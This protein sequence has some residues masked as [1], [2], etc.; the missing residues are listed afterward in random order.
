MAAPPAPGSIPSP[1]PP[2]RQSQRQ[3]STGAAHIHGAGRKETRAGPGAAEPLAGV[4]GSARDSNPPARLRA[5]WAEAGRRSRQQAKPVE[6]RSASAAP[7]RQRREEQAKLE[8]R[9]RPAQRD[10]PAPPA[11]PRRS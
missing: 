7:Q 10:T 2:H 6:G 8:T 3:V 9:P 11:S 5:R 1:S 4:A